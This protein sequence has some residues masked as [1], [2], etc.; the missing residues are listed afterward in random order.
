MLVEAEVVDYQVL[1]LVELVAVEMVQ[2]LLDKIML[3]ELQEQKTLVVE[4]AADG[5]MDS[6]N[7]VVPASSSSLILH[8]YSKS[9]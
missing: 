9:L 8:K 3:E 1:A 4:E 6:V 7:Q 5:T 2:Q